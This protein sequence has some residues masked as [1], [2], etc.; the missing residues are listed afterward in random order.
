MRSLC[1]PAAHVKGGSWGGPLERGYMV[2]KI[3][4]AGQK[5]CNSAGASVWALVLET[6]AFTDTLLFQK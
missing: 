6:I 3:P 4:W 1:P 5:R 2:E